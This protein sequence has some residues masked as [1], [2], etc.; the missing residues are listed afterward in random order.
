[1]V[2]S[3][4]HNHMSRESDHLASSE[5]EIAGDKR[6]VTNVP[7]LLPPA[8][9]KMSLLKIKYCCWKLCGASGVIA[10]KCKALLEV[11]FLF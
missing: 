6:R 10:R 4:E 8:Y 9:V 1:M 5:L 2:I 11:K 7:R 3:K